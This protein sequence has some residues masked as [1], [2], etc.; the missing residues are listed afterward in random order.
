MK[1]R[2]A[3]LIL[4]VPMMF[5]VGCD[6]SQ[7]TVNGVQTETVT[8]DDITIDSDALT[9]NLALM[10]PQSSVRLGQK[11]GASLIGGFRKPDRAVLLKE[12]P[13]GFG[14]GFNSVGWESP[15]RTVSMVGREDDLVLALDAWNSISQEKHDDIL[16]RY[17]FVYGEPTTKIEGRTAKYAFWNSGSVRLMICTVPETKETFTVTTVLGLATLMD[18]LRMNVDSAQ[19]DVASAD[20]M[21][22]TATAESGTN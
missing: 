7:F 20:Q 4:L 1:P 6:A 12:L 16:T 14:S 11:L 2:V 10:T 18:R 19:R 3:H 21:L 22:S 9:S 8:A 17:T 15:E 13:P 5:I